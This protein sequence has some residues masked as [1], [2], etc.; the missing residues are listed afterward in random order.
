MERMT[1]DVRVG[2]ALKEF[3]MSTNVTDVLDPD[4]YSNLWCLLKQHLITVPG[5]YKPINDRPDYIYILLHHTHGTNTFCV[6]DDRTYKINTIFRSYLSE[7]GQTVIRR[8]FEKEFKA[9]F[10]N[11][12][13]G[14]L[15]NNPELKIKEAIEEFLNDHNVA[16]NHI[17]YSM[18]K[19]DWYRYNVRNEKKPLC[20]LCF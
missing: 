9:A 2:S 1:V 20:P 11:Y 13:R 12:M 5:N 3:I 17:S 19:K 18:L 7:S 10:R 8:H 4:K 14:A 15:N 6:N 16:M